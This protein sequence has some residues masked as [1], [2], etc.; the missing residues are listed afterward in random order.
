MPAKLFVEIVVNKKGDLI[1][2]GLKGDVSNLN[3]HLKGTADISRRLATGFKLLVSTWALM[4]IKSF[5][6]DWTNLYEEMEKAD[7]LLAQAAANS[8]KYSSQWMHSTKEMANAVQ[9]LTGTH[10]TTTEMG[11]RLLITF[12]EITTDMLPRATLAMINYA[13]FTGVSMNSAAKAVG[14]SSMGLL[15]DLKRVGVQVDE[16][17][18]RTKGF[19]GIL[20]QLENQMGGQAETFRKTTAGQWAAWKNE[21]KDTKIE[22]GEFFDMFIV[23]TGLL[24]ALTTKLGEFADV[25]KGMKGEDLARTFHEI[26]LGVIEMA[27]A[28]GDIID[29]MITGWRLLGIDKAPAG[30]KML[31]QTGRAGFAKGAGKIAGSYGDKES[32]A[33][34]DEIY[35]ENLDALQDIAREME[36]INNLETK[37]LGLKEKILR[38]TKLLSPSVKSYPTNRDIPE[39]S[40]WT[41]I[42]ESFTTDVTKI[43]QRGWVDSLANME[44]DFTKFAKQL[45]VK[46]AQAFIQNIWDMKAFSVV[47]WGQIMTVAAA[48]IS[49]YQSQDKVGGTMS[50]AMAGGMIGGPAGAVLGGM[51]GMLLSTS[52]NKTEA[53]IDFV[54]E[55]IAGE[56][57][58]IGEQWENTPR[59]KEVIDAAQEA[60]QS[61]INLYNQIALLSEAKGLAYGIPKTFTTGGSGGNIVSEVRN[62]T[63]NIEAYRDNF[64][65]LK[66]QLDALD[67]WRKEWVEGKG[68]NIEQLEKHGVL[69][70]Y[71]T[72]LINQVMEGV[73][74]E[75]TDIGDFMADTIG[76]A[77]LNSLETGDYD[78]FKMNIKEGLYNSTV[79]AL[80]QAFVSKHMFAK[81]GE[82]FNVE[83][84]TNLISS[85]GTTGGPS[86]TEVV[87]G[88]NA[89]FNG[90]SGLF[91]E[92]QPI[93]EALSTGMTGLQLELGINTEALYSNIES[94]RD[95]L[96]TINDT[97]HSLTVSDLAPALSQKVFAAEYERLQGGAG[98]QEGLDD[99]IRYIQSEY[100]PFMRD[101]ATDYAGSFE[102]VIEDLRAL[103]EEPKDD[104]VDV[105]NKIY[106]NLGGDSNSLATTLKE[107]QITGV[108][109]NAEDL[110]ALGL[111]IKD[112]VIVSMTAVLDQQAAFLNQS[113][114]EPPGTS[115]QVINGEL[116]VTDDAT[117]EVLGP[118]EDY[119]PRIVRGGK[120]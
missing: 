56:V 6:K 84:L 19:I 48:G 61:Q 93:W 24:G 57:R 65:K 76:N 104:I 78:T 71:L 4:K 86:E 50:G 25:I 28:V 101:Y 77:F 42:W 58:L 64:P 110:E 112:G 98:T 70:E 41:N 63:E 83:S 68:I 87:E 3:K 60:M 21:I 54:W 45:N 38:L 75:I 89:A 109:V 33:I 88:I 46:M 103:E 22:L 37:S 108:H 99:F 23:D 102:K 30:F 67:A 73:E 52:K 106:E 111:T 72:D 100:L 43:F 15:G 82:A 12:D 7:R 39:I 66:S 79:E 18:Y 105:L 36:K 11:Q 2:K 74:E 27:A 81:F 118:I 94:M 90:L 114:R 34:W 51:G 115:V 107:L 96:N 92:M 62:I 117:G 40:V 35:D 20:G 97:I 1:L 95:Y 53:S 113:G 116:V 5:T 14:K 47:N 13:A 120:T 119:I 16:T 91:I 80:A 8:G 9:D 59:S 44:L 29:M 32:A 49:A 69:N 31:L 26:A 85:Y 10:R 55:V 17:T